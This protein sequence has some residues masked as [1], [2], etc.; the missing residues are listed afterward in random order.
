M[1]LV[2]TAKIHN[3]EVRIYS[4]HNRG[5][6]YFKLSYFWAGEWRGKLL[7]GSKLDDEKRARALARE[8]ATA[9]AEG[10]ADRIED[11]SRGIRT[12]RAAEDS[13]ALAGTPVDAAAREYALAHRMLEGTGATILDA[14]EFYAKRHV[15]SGKS[16]LVRDAVEQFIEGQKADG[17]SEK[18]LQD[19]RARLRR[20]A[21]ENSGPIAEITTGQIKLWLRGLKVSKRTRNNFLAL[22]KTFFHWAQGEDYLARN[23]PTAPDD[24]ARLPAPSEIHVHDADTVAKLFAGAIEHEPLILPYLAIGYFAAIRPR[25]MQ[26]MTAANIRFHHGDIEIKDWQAKRTRRAL[27]RRLVPMQPNLIAWLTV[28]PAQDRIATSRSRH[29]VARLAKRLGVS[30]HHDV[31]RHTGISNLVALTGNVDQVALWAGNSRQIIY[32]S[33]LSQV[34]KTEAKLFFSIEPPKL[35]KVLRIA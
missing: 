33:Y 12:L 32:Q 35:D 21:R 19:I 6:P 5:R 34:T 1:A 31:M 8:I 25:E 3:Q 7:S 13:L 27:H 9:M 17:A 15:K 20:F 10:R 24:I 11:F 16:I 28:F 2:H 30:W 18:Y 4:V 29:R 26:R 22:I 14:A 23:L